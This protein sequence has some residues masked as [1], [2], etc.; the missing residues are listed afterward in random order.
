MREA[1]EASDPPVE[2]EPIGRRSRLFRKYALLF[3]LLVSSV[4]IASGLVETYFSYQET[5]TAL[6]RIQGE[7]AKAAAAVIEQFVKEVEARLGWTMHAAFMPRAESLAQRRID[8]F[9]LLRQAPA[10]TEVS[11]LDASGREQILVSRLAMDQ[12]GSGKNFAD[13]PRFRTARSDG[14]YIS[15]VYFRR[16]SEPYLTIALGGRG[17]DKGVTAAEVNAALK[18]AAHKSPAVV[19]CSVRSRLQRRDRNGFAPFSLFFF[20]NNKFRKTP[21]SS[22]HATSR[23]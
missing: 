5:R 14:H 10:I 15:P 13:D 1:T 21:K 11:Y 2:K 17:R 18:S 16:E 4:L 6:L 22:A 7:K 12:I 19:N 3:S 20:Q 8:Y 9:R 23:D